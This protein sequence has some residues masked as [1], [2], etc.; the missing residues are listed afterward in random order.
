MPASEVH[1]PETPV[2]QL[3]PPG[4][5]PVGIVERRVVHGQDLR[6]DD[7]WFPIGLEKIAVEHA[8]EG[9]E[10]DHETPS[11]LVR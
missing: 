8:D 10:E 7:V 11:K 4:E 2:V 1:G 5:I 3:D 9:R 6:Q